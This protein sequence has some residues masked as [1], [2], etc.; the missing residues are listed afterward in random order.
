[1]QAPF[2]LPSMFGGAMQTDHTAALILELS[3]A[4]ERQHVELMRAWSRLSETASAADKIEREIVYREVCGLREEVSKLRAA[5]DANKPDPERGLIVRF[6]REIRPANEGMA[7]ILAL[8]ASAIE[9][10]SHLE[11]R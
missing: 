4:N 10:G 6:I 7:A 3:A 11:E 5:L 2:S 1:M 9:G 8:L